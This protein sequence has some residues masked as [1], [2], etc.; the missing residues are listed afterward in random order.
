MSSQMDVTSHLNS[1]HKQQLTN[2]LKFFQSK[3]N[4][5]AKEIEAAFEDSKEMRLLEEMYSKDDVVNIIDGLRDVLQSTIRSEFEKYSH[6]SAL[7]LRHL[8]LQ[9]EGHSVTLSVNTA[10]LEDAVLL[11]GIKKLELE[12]KKKQTVAD[13]PDV[14]GSKK[15]AA[16]GN[17]PDV[18]L[19]TRLKELEDQ[20]KSLQTRFDKLQQ[21]YMSTS[22]EANELKES[23]DDLSRQVVDLKRD[24]TNLQSN[25]TK[26][27]FTELETI[28]G[29]LSRYKRDS[30]D[31]T[32]R[33]ETEL[34]ATQEQ[35]SD[36][37]NKSP[38]FVQMKQMLQ[39]KNQQLKDARQR[40]KE[41][42][43]SK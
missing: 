25:N 20:H 30:E 36:R 3:I 9:A 37:I 32:K 42:E 22:R 41:L 38:Q 27:T 14:S 17:A 24:M 26:A 15:L 39:T 21:Q 34:K 7:F 35:L 29:E 43:D 13:L 19:V 16:L 28:R 40:V 6:Q 1:S 10:E 8:F 31:K 5:Q 33:L 18:K 2:Y 4:E 23:K 11:S 12:D